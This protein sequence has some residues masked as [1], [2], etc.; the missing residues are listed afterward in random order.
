MIVGRVSGGAVVGHIL[1]FTFPLLCWKNH[2]IIYLQVR[3]WKDILT[4]I[5]NKGS[6]KFNSS[7]KTKL[8]MFHDNEMTS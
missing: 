2:T 1:N 5:S 8:L 7:L 6:D 4:E 3:L